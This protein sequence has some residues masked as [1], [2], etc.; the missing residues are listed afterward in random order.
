MSERF[1]TDSFLET[2]S[3]EWAAL[4]KRFE[5]LTDAQMLT[6]GAAG[7][8]TP[9]QLLVHVACWHRWMA[10]RLNNYASGFAKLEP[11]TPEQ[12]DE[13]NAEFVARFEDWPVSA[14][15]ELSRDA[16]TRGVV[17][18]RGSSFRG[19]SEDWQRVIL[20]NTTNHYAEHVDELDA[21]IKGL[22]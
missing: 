4:R 14:V 20:A 18:I 21:F 6:P 16:H 19:F 9:K 2:E 11:F 7:E 17:S 15:R 12:V 10:D 13:M 8:W 5:R 1:D 22:E 3:Q